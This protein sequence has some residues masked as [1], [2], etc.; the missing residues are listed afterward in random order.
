METCFKLTLLNGPL[1]GQALRLPTGEFTL[2]EDEEND[3]H[4]ALESGATAALSASEQG[5]SLTTPTPC[6]VGGRPWHG[7][8]L[9]L[10]QGIDL[11]GIHFV[12][13]DSDS[14]APLPK[15]VKRRTKSRAILLYVL[16]GTLLPTLGIIGFFGYT[17]APLPPTPP[18]PRSW[19][20]QALKNEPGLQAIWQSNDE[21]LLRGHCQDSGHLAALSQRLQA[22]G[23][24]LQQEAVC[25]D[26][27]RQALRALLNSYGYQNMI[28]TLQDN[29]DATIDG[30]IQGNST[31]LAQALDQ[32]PGLG[33][34]QF[35]DS[36]AQ[37]LERLINAL[38]TEGLLEGISAR[39]TEHAWLLSGHITPPQQERLNDLLQRLNH[40]GGAN[41]LPL[42]FIGMAGD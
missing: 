20:P 32:L 41:T 22:S 37:T 11:A 9:P 19:L 4:L 6:W 10:N 42:R 7:D 21:L 29:G 17:A 23:V 13:T 40:Q 34:W 35:T 18:T 1:R 31:P 28:I 25:N 30:D 36:G 12:L 27:L 14:D 5:I 26:T 33:R 3:L 15:I 2:G 38:Q 8:H 16:F 24:H 39:R